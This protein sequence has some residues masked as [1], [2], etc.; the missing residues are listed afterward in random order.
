MC[1]SFRNSLTVVSSLFVFFV[2]TVAGYAQNARF[3]GQ[4]TDPQN[5]AISHATVEITNQET[6]VQLHTETDDSGS[7]T[8]PY[9]TAG[10]YRIVFRHRVL[11]HDVTL[12]WPAISS[13][14][15]FLGS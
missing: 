3:T 9:L 7:Y 8:V 5:A 11:V 4:V 10:R 14:R 13:T 12:G 15:S 2:L 1:A 6:G